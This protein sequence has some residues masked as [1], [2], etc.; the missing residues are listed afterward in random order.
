MFLVS[1]SVKKELTEQEISAKSFFCGSSL[2]GAGS[3]A[4]RWFI[5]LHKYFCA[6]LL[7]MI[8]VGGRG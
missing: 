5:Y 4:S 1:E 3:A 7:G 2:E 6:F 8:F